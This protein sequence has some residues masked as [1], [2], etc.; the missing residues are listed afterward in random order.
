MSTGL[1]LLSLVACQAPSTDSSVAAEAPGAAAESQATDGPLLITDGTVVT[2]DATDTIIEDGAVAV[3][4]G[5]IVAVG[6]ASELQAEY[7]SARRVSAGGGIIMPGLINTH[8]HVPMVLFR[9]LADDLKLMDWLENHIFPA[10]AK[11][12]DEEFVRWGTRLACLEMLRGGTTTFVDMY[13][14]EDAI[15]EEADRCGMRAVVGESLIDFPTPDHKTWD[16]AVA[17]TRNFVARWKGH[18]RITPAVAPHAPYTVS[19]DH[20]KEAHALAAEL[21]VPLVIHLAED[22]TAIERVTKATGFSPVNY[23]DSLGI[24]DDRVLAAHMVWPSPEEIALLVER[25]VGVAHNPQSNMKISAGVAP[26]PAMLAAGVAVGLGTDGAASN[27]DLDMWEEIDT[28]AKLHK[29]TSADATVVSA[30]EALRMATID[31]ARALD[32]EAEI[33]SLEVGKRADV[34]LVGTDGFH[35]QPSYN[36]YS[37]L[38]YSTK[39]SDV[40]TVIIEGRVVM[41]QGQVLTVDAAG[42]LAKAAEYRDRIAAE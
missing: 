24:L 37:L 17:Y 39:S 29:V 12:V 6:T 5:R 18:P 32:M 1:M 41:E 35:Q 34:I 8:T 25:D 22:R 3:A 30:R 19:A 11:H 31:G 15:A 21:E 33:G 16:A 38:T 9:G 7:A 14:F 10:E 4:D 36:A 2:M 28:A 26:V 20:L 23:L 40:E 13:F 42:V 27:N